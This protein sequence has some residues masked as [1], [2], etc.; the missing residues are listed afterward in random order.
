MAWKIDREA[1]EAAMAEG[2]WSAAG[3]RYIPPP[4]IDFPRRPMHGIGT[5]TALASTAAGRVAR[6]R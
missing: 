3:S 2:A 6:M 4:C 1:T 5:M